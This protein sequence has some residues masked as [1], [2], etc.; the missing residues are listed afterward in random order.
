MQRIEIARPTISSAH[1]LVASFVVCCA[2]AAALI[3]SFPLQLSIITIFLFAG[4][5]NLMELRYFAARMPVRW[6]K[7]RAYY[8]V[9][10]AGVVVLTSAYLT[11]YFAN[12]NW[13][14]DSGVYLSLAWNTSF[15]SWIGVLFYLR[16]KQTRRDW[17]WAVPL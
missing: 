7:S 6:G 13:L 16:G 10:I 5:H 1:V 9:A 17:G 12:D 3:G 14:W 11:L 8:S 15:I 2:I 4:V